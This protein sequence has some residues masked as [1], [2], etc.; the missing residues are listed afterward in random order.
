MYKNELVPVKILLNHLK[1]IDQQQIERDTMNPNLKIK[2]NGAQDIISIK[3]I[4]TRLGISTESVIAIAARDYQD[5]LR[6]GLFLVSKSKGDK[7]TFL[8]NGVIKFVD[9]CTI[10]SDNSIPEEGYAEL[11]S[12]LGYDVLWQDLDPNNAIIV[13]RR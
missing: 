9:A 4:A 3:D 2:L 11:I 6:A 1:T 12:N 8:L 5:Y 7:L 10:L 13:R